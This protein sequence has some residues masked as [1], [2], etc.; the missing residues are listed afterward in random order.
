MLNDTVDLK[1]REATELQKT[2]EKQQRSLAKQDNAVH[3][4][5]KPSI[6]RSEM[7]TMSE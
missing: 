2:I 6:S 1:T 5:R 3:N 4:V 7:L